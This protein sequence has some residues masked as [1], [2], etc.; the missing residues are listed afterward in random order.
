M[1]LNTV[2]SAVAAAGAMLCGSAQAGLVNVGGVVWDPDSMFDLTA[3]SNLFELPVTTAGQELKG[4]GHINAINNDSN[5]CVGCEL[6]FTFSGYTLLNNVTAATPNFAFSGGVFNFY[7]SPVN[8]IAGNVSSYSDGVLW[9]TLV[10]ADPLGI[11]AT[12]TG[13]ATVPSVGGISGQGAGYLNVTGGMAAS[14]FDTNSEIGGVDFVYSSS[15]SPLNIALGDG[16]THFGSAQIVGNSIPEPGALA[17]LGL[18]LAGLGL[19]RRN[20]KQAS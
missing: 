4:Y 1:K 8:R 16:M 14:N 18:G 6:T 5:F 2:L 7:V 3:S 15:F 12:L 17:L 10:G 20:K 13:S 9:L 11:G 19:A